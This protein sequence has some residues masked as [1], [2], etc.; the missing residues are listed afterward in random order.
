MV[1]IDI[2]KLRPLDLCRLLN[3]T[4]LGEV[5]SERQVY[6]HRDRVGFRIGDGRYIDL[7]RYTNW[8]FDVYH[9]PKTKPDP[10]AYAN[11]KEH[12]RAYNAATSLAG[13]NIGKL[14]DPVTVT[15]TSLVT[16]SPPASVIV[17]RKV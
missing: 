12:S 7:F 8:L 10:N 1:A 11:K 16:E 9:S 15:A 5:I 17:T 13:R 14:P 3:S 4:P 6:R 2:R